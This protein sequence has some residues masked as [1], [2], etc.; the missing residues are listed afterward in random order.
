MKIAQTLFQHFPY[1]FLTHDFVKYKIRLLHTTQDKKKFTT[2]LKIKWC[3][4]NRID[5][6]R[7]LLRPSVSN[8]KRGMVCLEMEYASKPPGLASYRVVAERGGK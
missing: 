4:I 3:F 1:P 5:S 2:I 6:K 8:T 7:E